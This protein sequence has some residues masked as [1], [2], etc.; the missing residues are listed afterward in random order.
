M[1]P[2]QRLLLLSSSRTADT[3]FLQHARQDIG[4]FLNG[5]VKRAVFLPYAGVRF[6]YDEYTAR[7]RDWFA[8]LD[9]E[10]HG[11]HRA[12]DLA[13]ELSRADLIIVGGGNTFHLLHELYRHNLIGTL[14]S[15]I[16]KGIGYLGWSAG[17][18][19]V[20][21]SIRTTND[22]PIIWPPSCEALDLVPFQINPHY[23]DAHPS[24][25]Q[26]ETRAERLAE[27]T[28]LNPDIPVVGLREGSSLHIET[29]KIHLLGKQPAR[30]SRGAH[31]WDAAPDSRIDEMLEYAGIRS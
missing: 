9:C 1:N 18:N 26:G 28:T 16:S 22:M 30:I 21:P 15:R 25:H 6:S 17:S 14:R 23:T 11:L 12:T 8:Q 5:S 27:F 24:G 19:I 4:S 10:V 13:Q 2:V 20:C 31:S 7:V 29:G 3:G